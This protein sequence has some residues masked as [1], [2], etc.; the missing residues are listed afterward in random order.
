MRELE[1]DAP[2]TPENDAALLPSSA[3]LAIVGAGRLGGSLAAAA[4]AAGLE[5][6]LAGRED[7]AEACAGA[8][9]VLLCVPDGEIEAASEVAATA[10]PRPGFVG[11]TSGATTLNFLA[12]ATAAGAGAFSL[13]PLQTFADSETDPRGAPCAIAGATPDAALLAG[14]LA[15]RLGMRP[16]AV[17]EE[18]RAAYHA[19]AS[20]ASNF[21]VAIEE[22]A[23]TL[24]QRSGASHYAGSSAS[25]PGPA[26]ARELLAPL[27]LRAAANWSEL[28]A[29]SLTGPIAR[30]DETTVDRQR[31]AIAELAPELTDM[32]EALV[33]RTKVLAEESS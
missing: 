18:H 31:A 32:Y 22:S 17:P 28:G 5:V 26:D 8:D 2:D 15:E 13:H 20:I 25:R 6:I 24:M 3:Q 27:V 29:S 1:R 4:T 21:L 10:E 12:A 14:E 30:G 9:V 23:V 7:A 33:A 11:H 16:F 19:A